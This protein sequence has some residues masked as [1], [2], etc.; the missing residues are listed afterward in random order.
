MEESGED[1]SYEHVAMSLLST[2]FGLFIAWSWNQVSESL[3]EQM[4]TGKAATAV[5]TT[6]WAI[7]V[8]FAATIITTEIADRLRSFAN[9]GQDESQKPAFLKF[10]DLFMVSLGY[11]VGWAWSDAL[12][13]VLIDYF[14][15]TDMKAMYFAYSVG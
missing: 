14:Y 2:A 6:L 12:T 5:T 4:S 7:G 1:N 10:V 13:H 8:T 3:G 11:V 15:Y 9:S